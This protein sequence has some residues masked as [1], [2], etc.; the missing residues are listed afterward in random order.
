MGT[1]ARAPQ[2]LGLDLNVNILT[3]GRSRLTGRVLSLS[4][5]TIERTAAASRLRRPAAPYVVS[6]VR[7]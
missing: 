3:E 2:R 1:V 4:P 7:P 5:L 6:P